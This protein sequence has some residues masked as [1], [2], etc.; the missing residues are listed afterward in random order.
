[1]TTPTNENLKRLH[2]LLAAEQGHNLFVAESSFIRDILKSDLRT[3]TI[4]DRDLP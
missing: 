1:M 4:E 2:D 3:T